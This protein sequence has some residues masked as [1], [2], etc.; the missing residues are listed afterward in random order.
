MLA[1]EVKVANRAAS[2]GGGLGRAGLRA[3]DHN[4]ASGA[5]K[6]KFLD[7]RGRVP[8]PHTPCL[9]PG[10]NFSELRDFRSKAAHANTDPAQKR[11]QTA[12]TPFP[13]SGK[14]YSPS[15]RTWHRK[16]FAEKP[17]V[18]AGERWREVATW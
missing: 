18:L 5:Y 11:G 1:A 16:S 4:Q 15:T 6:N 8:L 13:E 9:D 10:K 17:A 14:P 3:A 12:S 2:E 7:F